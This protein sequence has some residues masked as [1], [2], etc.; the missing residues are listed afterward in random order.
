[1]PT[2]IDT[3]NVITGVVISDLGVS[4]KPRDDSFLPVIRPSHS[5][6]KVI[7]GFLSSSAVPESKIFP[8]DSLV[9]STDG[10][11]SHSHSYVIPYRFIPNSNVSVLLPRRSMSLKAKLF[12]ALA[13]TQSRW[14]FSYGRKPKGARLE[15][16][17][18]PV[19]PK[20][21]EACEL[22]DLEQ[23]YRGLMALANKNAPLKLGKL[24]PISEL[25]TIQYG[26]S[27][28]LNHLKKDE[29]G[30][31]FVSRT[32]HNNGIS[33]RVARTRD[34][35]TPAGCIT[36]ALG[37]SVLETFLQNEPTYQG[38]DIAILTPI[39]KMTKNE[40]LWY[41]AAIRQHQFRFSFGRQANRQLPAL[42]IPECPKSLAEATQA[43]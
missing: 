25:F 23:E 8:P 2:V 29:K 9:I 28:E 16:L 33:G 21:A 1:M 41:V 38:R 11:G 20:W 13:I 3:F 42:L 40:K 17:D 6:Q 7:A 24:R 5:F 10:Q 32:S 19:L 35:P 4:E 15:T 30:I 26:N 22:P 34:E 18:L 43:I 31:A 36:V 12:Y 14:R 39:N 37:G 27:Y